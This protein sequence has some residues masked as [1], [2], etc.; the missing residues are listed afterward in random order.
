VNV[1]RAENT[2]A[3]EVGSDPRVPHPGRAPRQVY[4]GPSASS[5]TRHIDVHFQ[6]AASFFAK[7]RVQGL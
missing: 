2:V 1:A 6:S 5:R 7:I 4:D 3:M